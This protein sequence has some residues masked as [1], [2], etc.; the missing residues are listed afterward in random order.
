MLMLRF[1]SC[2]SK[3]LPTSSRLSAVVAAHG[4]VKGRVAFLLPCLLIVYEYGFFSMYDDVSFIV[5]DVVVGCGKGEC[6]V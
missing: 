1:C 5:R 2:E 4:D 6:F 3:K